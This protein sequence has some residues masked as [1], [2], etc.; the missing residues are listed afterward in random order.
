MNYFSVVEIEIFLREFWAKY[1]FANCFISVPGAR[2][3][4]TINFQIDS[5][6]NGIA[7]VIAGRT[8]VLSLVSQA[9]TNQRSVF[10]VSTNQKSVF[11]V[12]ANEKAALP[13]AP[14]DQ[15][16]V[17]DDLHVLAP[18][19]HPRHREAALLAS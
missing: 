13:H 1:Y 7:H 11:I 14:D 15:S 8:R 9:A 2:L 16:S 4:L 17:S 5:F 12:S 6:G 10:N 3:V 19:S 18:S